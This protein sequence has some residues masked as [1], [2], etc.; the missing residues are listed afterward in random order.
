MVRVDDEVQSHQLYKVHIITK[1]QLVCQVEAVV[2]V[3]LDRSN[4]SILKDVPVDPCSN[5]W[6]LCNDVHRVLK[7][8]LPVVLLV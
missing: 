8:V 6:E 2:L 4:L 5:C 3:H 1:A 7:G